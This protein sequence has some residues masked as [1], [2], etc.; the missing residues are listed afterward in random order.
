MREVDGQHMLASKGAAMPVEQGL[1]A[2]HSSALAAGKYE[3]VQWHGVDTKC[4]TPLI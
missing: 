3:T 1:I 2:A 4:V